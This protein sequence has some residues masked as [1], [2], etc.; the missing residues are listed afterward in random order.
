M[1]ASTGNP[2]PVNQVLDPSYEAADAL[3]NTAN[4]T[5]GSNTQSIVANRDFYAEAAHQTAQTSP[6]SPFNGTSGTGH[7]TLANRPTTCA[8]RVG[9]W[10]T[11]QG[12]WNQ[13]GNGGQ[14]VLYVCD[15]ATHWTLDYTPYT[16][17][18]PLIAG[19]GTGSGG[20]SPN[21]PTALLVVVQ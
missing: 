6:T 16:Y 18:H 20:N 12:S 2:G 8:P 14:G 13:S 19:G 3:P 7:G 9:Y 17:P 11:D 4:T 10:A 5:L 15:S 1:L 21:P